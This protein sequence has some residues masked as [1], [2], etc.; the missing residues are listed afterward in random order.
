[1]V[2]TVKWIRGEE[3]KATWPQ[4]DKLLTDI[5]TAGVGVWSVENMSAR[6]RCMF[7]VLLNGS[8]YGIVTEDI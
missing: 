8:I 4:V 1:M 2:F 7:T 5:R 6:G 3:K